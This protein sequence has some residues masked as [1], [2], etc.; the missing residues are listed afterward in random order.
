MSKYR[1]FTRAARHEKRESHKKKILF[2]GSLAILFLIVFTSLILFGNKGNPKQEVAEPT[3]SEVKQEDD[4]ED[5]GK[6]QVAEKEQEEKEKKKPKDKNLEP[7]EEDDEEEKEEQEVELKEVQS[8]DSNVIKAYEGDW[9]PIGTKQ[10]GPHTTT[11]A[12]GS[13]DRVE[14]REAV[15][16]VTDLK[17]DNLEELWIGRGGEQK[18]IATVADKEITD[19]YR[20]YL[21]WIDGEGWQPTKYEELEYYSK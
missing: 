9:D 2:F 21:D 15:L 16:M 4:K 13:D 12:D 11:Y 6:N 20:V 5:E 3:A 10:E 14:I 18:V 19:I 8:S 17:E 7:T 1:R